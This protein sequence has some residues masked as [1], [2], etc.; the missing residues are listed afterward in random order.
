MAQVTAVTTGFHP[1]PKTFAL[2]WVWHKKKKKNSMSNSPQSK[3]QVIAGLS[4]RPR[5][6]IVDSHT[7]GN[8][9]SNGSGVPIV[10]QR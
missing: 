1:W 2:L 3:L 7:K 10:A 5:E 8:I 6:L 4:D 9:K